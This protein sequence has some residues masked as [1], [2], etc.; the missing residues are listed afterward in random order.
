[1]GDQRHAQDLR[2]EF[3][4][5]LQRLRHL[6]AAAFA[7]AAGMNLRL[8][9]PN[10]AAEFRAQPNRPRRPKN[11][12]C[13]AGS[14]RRTCAKFPC[15]DIREHS[16]LIELRD[17]NLLSS[18]VLASSLVSAY[19]VSIC[20]VGVSVNRANSTTE[21]ATRRS[22]AARGLD[23]LQHRGLVVPHFL[24]A[25]DA[26]LERNPKCDAELVGDAL[27]LAS[28]SRPRSRGWA[29]SGKCRRAWRATAR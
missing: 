7:A 5:F 14:R 26:L 18:R 10:F 11:K 20:G 9:D 15:P 3:M 24:R 12:A 27:R 19:T 8:D 17:Y 6:D 1:M 28:S 29:D 13:R 22:R 16:C 4:H 23:I 25:A 2:G 21:P